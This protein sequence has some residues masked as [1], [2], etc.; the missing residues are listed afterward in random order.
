MVQ[1]EL[2]ILTMYTSNINKYTTIDKQFNRS[3][4]NGAFGKPCFC[5]AQKEGV[6]D[7]NGENDECA[8]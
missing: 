5:P 4:R 2:L 6:L 1:S 8:F 7:E 3:P